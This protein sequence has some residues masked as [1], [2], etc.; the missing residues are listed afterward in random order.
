MQLDWMQGTMVAAI[1]AGPTPSIRECEDM[2]EFRCTMASRVVIRNE[3]RP[4]ADDARRAKL[5]RAAHVPPSKTYPTEG[6]RICS[7]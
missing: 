1:Q 5:P 6:T 3:P 2:R 7:R 4:D